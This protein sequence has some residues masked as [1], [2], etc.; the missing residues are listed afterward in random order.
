MP[1]LPTRS[2]TTIVANT[3]A[4]IQGRAAALIDFAEGSPLRAIVEGF[5]GVFLWFQALALQILAAARLST[6]SGNDVDTFTADFMPVVP[7]TTSPRL[8]SQAA[9]GLLV[10]SRFTAGPSSCFIPVGAEAQT[11]DRTQSFLVTA[12]PS[13]ATF[14]PEL[15]GYT[16][17]P[18]LAS[19][20][21]PAAAQISG[22]SGNV[23]AGAVSVVRSPL[24]GID[25]VSNPAAFV[26]GAD[27]ES[28][29][30]L[31]ARFAAYILGLS[32][33][34]IYGLT[35]AIQGAEV[36]LQ[37]CIVENY[38]FSGAFHPG[39][40]FVVVDDGSGAPPPE[41]MDAIRTAVYS[42]RPLGIEAAIFPPQIK[43]VTVQMQVTTAQGYDHNTVVGLVANAVADGIN[44]LGLGM[45]LD[46]NRLSVWAYSV[47]GV[48][49]VSAVTL[50]GA[51]GDSASVS[52]S[53]PTQDGYAQMPIFTIKC[54]T[55][56]VS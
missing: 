51:A 17:V 20:T 28:D 27:Q 31:K 16:L 2:F 54:Q 38:Y 15:N 7:G 10:F 12:D 1:T 41:F 55:V 19:I 9:N 50:N 24:T 11:S 25:S 18:G 40:F 46:F 35:A 53:Q 48:T 32:R 22:S 3:V 29:S 56:E 42:V 47:Q 36:N 30:A 33:G 8:G 5:A 14:S 26:A 44:S 6:S 49:G 37:W 13:L 52:A 23:Q 21:V 34:D 4:G 45:R 43:L 39:F